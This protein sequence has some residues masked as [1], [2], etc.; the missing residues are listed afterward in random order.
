MGF[1]HLCIGKD[2]DAGRDWGQEEKGTTE[3]EMAGWH[4]QL[5]GHEF[6]WTPDAKLAPHTARPWD[7]GGPVGMRRLGGPCGHT[8]A[9]GER[10]GAATSLAADVTCPCGQSS[11]LKEG[12]LASEGTQDTQGSGHLEFG[13]G[14]PRT[15]VWL[16]LAPEEGARAGA[17]GRAGSP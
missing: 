15:R 6:E 8:P 10:L 9:L 11:A 12:R 4:H 13:G 1:F 5:D 14:A 3:D 17:G 16:P 7:A 2:S